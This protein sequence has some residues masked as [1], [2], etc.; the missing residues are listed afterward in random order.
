MGALSSSLKVTW[1]TEHPGSFIFFQSSSSS[2][3]F[4]TDTGEMKYLAAAAAAA[5]KSLV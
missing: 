3:E 4:S 2:F 1:Q 5:N